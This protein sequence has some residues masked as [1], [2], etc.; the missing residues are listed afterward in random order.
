[1]RFARQ[2]FLA[3]AVLGI[4]FVLPMYFLERRI[5]STNPP[6]ITHPEYF[7]GFIGVT[8]A[9]QV[10]FLVI[11]R[12]P[13]K[14]RPIMLVGVLEKVSFGLAM[15]ML[16]AAGRI[17]PDVFAASLVDLAFA[18]LFAIAYGKTPV[19]EGP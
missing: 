7:Y 3:A 5:G 13:V 14:Y 19:A 1:M 6:P 17:P 16:F 12:N 2:T 15:P 9:W 11:A 10:L 8:L 4:A 18:V